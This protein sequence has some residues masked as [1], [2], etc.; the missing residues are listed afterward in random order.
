MSH[1]ARLIRIG[2]VGILLFT[3]AVSFCISPAAHAQVSGASLSGTIMDPSG[4]IVPNAQIVITDVNTGVSRTVSSTSGGL[5]TAPNLLPGVY[6]LSVTAPGFSTLEQTGITLTV[7]AQQV[8]DVKLQVGQVSQT[9]Q[10]SGEGMSVELASSSISAQVNATTVRE[11]PLNGRSWTDLATLQ[12]GVNSIETQP[13]FASGSDRGNRGFGSQASI[14]GARPQQNNYRLDGVSINDYSNGAPGS[15]LGGNLGV[16]AIQEFSVLTSNY[17]AEYGKTSGGVINAITKSG[18]NQ[19]H[20]SAYEFLRNSALDARNYFDAATIPPFRQ[21]QFGI[22]GGGPILKGRTFIFGDYEGIRE[23]KGITAVNVVPSTNARNG[24]LNIDATKAFPAGCTSNGITGSF[25]GTAYNQC[26]IAT[27]DPSAVKYMQFFPLPGL[28]PTPSG[29][30]NTY[31]STLVAQ[32]ILSENFFTTRV[33]HKFSD[34]DSLFG[35]YVFDRTPYTLPDGFNDVLLGDLTFRQVF[36]LEETHIFNP[37]FINTVRFGFNR[38]RVDNNESVSAILPAAS[39]VSLGAVPGRAAAQVSIGGL[40]AFTGGVGGNTNYFFRWNSFQPSDDAFVTK[41]THSLKFGFQAERMQLNVQSYS[42]PNGVF[43][44]A[45][46]PGFLTNQPTKFNSALTGSIFDRGFRQS[47]FG[48]YVQDDWRFRPNLTLN[49]GLRYEMTTVMSETRGYLV[50]LVHPTDPSARQGSPLYTNPT[51]HNFEPRIGFAYD[52]FRNGKT[53]L[54]GGIGMF[55]VLPLP[56][57]YFLMEN[58]AAPYYL[59]GSTSNKALLANK[60]FAGA[61]P[62]L[63]PSSLRTA[64]IENAPHRNYVMQWNMNVQ[65]ALTPSLTATVGYVGSRGVHMPF[66]VDDIDMVIPTLVSGR[67]VWPCGPNGKG[68]PCGVGFLPTGTQ[69]VPVPSAQINT[70]FGSM[71]GMMYEGMSY[72]N[73]LQV[74]VIKSMSHGV[75]VQGAFTWAKSMD[76]GSAT[77]AGDQFGNSIQSLDYFDPRLGRALSDF[78]VGRTLVINAI[79]EVPGLKSSMSAANWL[80]NGWQIGGIFKASDGVPFTAT[81][82]SNGDVMGKKSGNTFG[83]PDRVAGPG[84]NTA[85]NPGNPIAYIKTQCFTLPTAPSAAFYAA[86]CDPQLGTGLQCFNLR[87][88]AGRNILIGPG[89]TDFDFSLFKNNHIRRISENFNIQF[90]AELFNVLNHPNFAPPP[91]PGNTDI[92]TPSG[93]PSPSVGVLTGTTTTSR[94]VQFALKFM[95]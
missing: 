94:E 4:A 65:R 39:D 5:Y 21:N 45:D 95:W 44:F 54:R 6:K 92:F 43:T 61:L 49:L 79:W 10:V 3:L 47:L 26:V 31:T 15:V 40:T 50:N 73:A 63:T 83:Y 41:G 91:T 46:I 20:G 48:A 89:L 69:A 7:G 38:N 24:I 87:G 68:D 23:S 67:Y 77:L 74:Q 81:F 52:P 62:L 86:N 37:N 85:V 90:R 22:S 18:T 33:D 78:N 75:Q 51:L 60:F 35:T 57:Q 32:R 82:G 56:S 14:S 59:L 30:L 34:N 71:R 27:P 72:Y 64:Y 2:Y 70:N 84:C 12:P 9:V 66:R 16:D 25:N 55:D 11:L 42:N 19:F 53:A 13:S 80:T 1:S 88:N 36:I 17:S 93:A 8:L 28:S 76:T 58:L 29:L